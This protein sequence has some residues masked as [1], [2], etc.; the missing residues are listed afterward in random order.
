MEAIVEKATSM[1]DDL[2]T[3]M[4]K[5]NDLN[6]REKIFGWEPTSYALLDK[7]HTDFQVRAPPDECWIQSAPLFE[8][9][10]T[11]CTSRFSR[12]GS[13]VPDEC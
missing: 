11:V 12:F 3:A 6:Q 1:Q 13:Q 7:M 10:C 8:A 4:L 5:A 9:P 2:E